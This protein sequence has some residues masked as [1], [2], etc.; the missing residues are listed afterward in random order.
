MERS[1]NREEVK[2][3]GEYFEVEYEQTSSEDGESDEDDE[4]EVDGKTLMHRIKL[5][6]DLKIR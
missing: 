4:Q 1:N 2:N 3:K 6:N 5:Q